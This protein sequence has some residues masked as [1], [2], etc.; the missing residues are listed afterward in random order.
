VGIKTQKSLCLWSSPSAKYSS[1]CDT[2][3]GINPHP[4]VELTLFPSIKGK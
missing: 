4:S 1:V 3:R 2:E